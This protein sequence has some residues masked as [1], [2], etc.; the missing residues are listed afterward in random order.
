MINKKSLKTVGDLI[1]TTM[2]VVVLNIVLQLVV[3]PLITH[4]H[5]EV[6][7]GNILY[8][9]G[10]IYIIPQAF[11]TALSNTR[12]IIRK[13]HDA[14]N[15]DYTQMLTLTCV[16]SALICGYIGLADDMSIGFSVLY[17]LF[18]V[19]YLIRAYT[20]VEF[21]LKLD[22]KGYFLYYC[23]SSVGYLIGLIFY[24]LTNIWLLIFIVGEGLGVAYTLLFG[25]LLSKEPRGIGSS[26]INK[27]FWVIAASLLMRDCVLHFDKV[28]LKQAISAEVV[29]HYF[30]VSFLAKT[31]QMLINPVNTL[32]MSYLTAKDAVFTKKTLLKFT[33]FSLGI[34][35]AFYLAC[36]IGTPIYVK[37]FYPS[38]Y[39]MV[40]AYSP[41][42]NLG[43]VIGFVSL[44]FMAVLLSQGKTK[45]HG[46]IECVSGG[47]YILAAVR[48]ISTHG[49]WGL[50][51][52]TLFLNLLKL[53]VVIGT[54]FL[55]T[56][57][58]ES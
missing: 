36:I 53:I 23:L 56:K 31:M 9:I 57:K 7:T 37:L 19:I 54:L 11:G 47:I 12:L 4:F 26:L 50:A 30:V 46:V 1:Y 51:Y 34:G 14:T 18:S 21:R 35:A 33:A 41:I 3:Y 15:A 29:T 55:T 38:L 49:I 6:V 10:F 25:K 2:A 28:V 17:G 42:V 39:D 52:V 44:L 20:Q 22:F 45:L 16:L 27:T 8:F 40:I 32:I 58:S 13:D 48:F 5:G 24:F 43:L